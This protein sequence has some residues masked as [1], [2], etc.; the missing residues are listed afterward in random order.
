MPRNFKLLEELEDGMRG[1]DGTISWG[2][3]KEDDIMLSDWNGSIVGPPHSAFENRIYTL[4]IHCGSD[5]PEVP[6][7]VKFLTK[8]HV[9]WVDSHGNVLKSSCQVLSHWQKNYTIKTVLSEL[10][11]MMSTKDCRNLKQPPEGTKY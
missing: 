9:P 1:G 5:Y 4:Q 8:V 6:P 7:T 3:Q 10:K 2:L 11:R